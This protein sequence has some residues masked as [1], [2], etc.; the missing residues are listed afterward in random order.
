MITAEHERAKAG[1]GADFADAVA[2]DFCDP[3]HDLFGA[4]WLTRLPNTGRSCSR[5]LVFASG[6]LVVNTGHEADTAIPDWSGA[7][8]DGVEMRTVQ[9]LEHWTLQTGGDQGALQLEAEAVSRPRELPD[10]VPAAVEVE[11][12]EQLLR[13][14]GTV[15][16]GGRTYPVR[17][18][19]RRVHWWGKFS[20]ERIARWRA[21]YA[22]SGAGRAVSAVAALPAGSAGHDAELRAAQFLD[23]EDA[24][25]FD[26]VR[27]S[28]V[29]GEDGMPSKVGL[30]LWRPDDEYPQRLGGVA[31]C[32]TRLERGDHELVV[33]F[34]RWS[35]DGE[36]AYGCYE[37]ARRA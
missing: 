4:A 11:Q 25:P 15:D 37:L 3:E 7:R 20:W 12:Y 36:P 10:G 18:L 2:L 13:L 17:C 24:L 6:E 8:L 30:E 19:G 23:D 31:V 29:Y 32:G 28:T 22:V 21:L 5:V 26:D 9:P 14:S 16:A 35:I 27:L 34:F 1:D 33:S